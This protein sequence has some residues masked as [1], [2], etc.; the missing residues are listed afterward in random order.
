MR[1]VIVAAF[2]GP[3]ALQTTEGPEPSVGAGEVLVRVEAIGIGLVDVLMRRGAFPALPLPFTPG[4]E[5]AGVIEKV[6]VGVNAGLAS[7]RVYAMVGSGGYASHVTVAVRDI[8]TLPDAVGFDEAVA[9]GVNSLVAMAALQRTHTK[10]GEQVLIRGGSGGIGLMAIQLAN[11]LGAMVTAIS[12]S[13]HDLQR[14]GANRVLNRSAPGRE[15]FDV[16]IDP[17]AGPDLPSFMGRLA[18]NGRLVVCGAAGGLPSADFGGA[19]LTSFS[20][21]LAIGTLSLD[22]ITPSER[23]AMLRRIFELAENGRLKPVIHA[24]YTLDDVAAAHREL[25]AGLVLGK[26]VALP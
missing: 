21:S 12:G 16:I 2:G 5:I 19:L 11:D 4:V 1:Q 6:G 25:E 14:F 3:H 24:K 17:V 8:V 7:R 26:L 18:G 20:K 15:E 10:E 22:S 13:R 23:A 9:L